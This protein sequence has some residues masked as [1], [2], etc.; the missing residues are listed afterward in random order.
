MTFKQ[1][2][3]YFL[4]GLIIGIIA[5]VFILGKKNT[6]FDYFPNA[7]VLKNIRIKNR[8]FSEEVFALINSNKIDTATISQILK[9]GNVDIRNK[10]KM[11]T[12]IQYNIKGKKELNTILLTIKNCDSTAYIESIRI[13]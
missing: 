13:E 12:C 4:G 2:L 7:R 5:V 9:K 11:D 1:R 3:P 10:I 8:V 6:S